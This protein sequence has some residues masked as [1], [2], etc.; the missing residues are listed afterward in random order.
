M[1]IEFKNKFVDYGLD[2]HTL[3]INYLTQDKKFNQYYTVNSLNN[4]LGNGNI[5]SIYRKLILLNKLSWEYKK[6]IKM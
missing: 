5:F 6:E 3:F 4:I 1:L 2:E